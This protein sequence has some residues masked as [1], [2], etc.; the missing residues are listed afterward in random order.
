MQNTFESGSIYRHAR[1]GV[2]LVVGLGQR[3]YRLDSVGGRPLWLSPKPED[4]IP[5]PL[6]AEGLEARAS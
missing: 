6:A 5:V 3:F 1:T 2:L 4:L